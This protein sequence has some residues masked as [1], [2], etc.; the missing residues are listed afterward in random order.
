MT[1][2]PMTWC[3]IVI[4]Q[5]ET[6]NIKTPVFENTVPNSATFCQISSSV[7][8]KELWLLFPSVTI[9]HFAGPIESRIV[10]DRFAVALEELA[11]GQQTNVETIRMQMDPDHPHGTQEN[12][13]IKLLSQPEPDANALSLEETH[14]QLRLVHGAARLIS[15]TFRNHE[16]TQAARDDNEP[17]E[18]NSISRKSGSSDLE[19]AWLE[20]LGISRR[21]ATLWAHLAA[22]SR[23]PAQ[24]PALDKLLSKS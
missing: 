22:I 1:R 10:R 5:Q 8:T 16:D 14:T 9:K 15:D 19:L 12:S 7:I 20:L 18:G 17:L 13:V 3:R 4:H 6:G 21:R 11:P 2:D 23:L 24:Q